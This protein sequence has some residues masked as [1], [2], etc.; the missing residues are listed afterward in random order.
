MIVVLVTMK[1]LRA[2]QIDYC[3]WILSNQIY[4][5][6]NALRICLERALEIAISLYLALRIELKSNHIFFETII[7]L[8]IVTME[9][10]VGYA[11]N[12]MIVSILLSTIITS[13]LIRL[14]TFK[15]T[16]RY[17]LNQVAH[18]EPNRCWSNILIARMF[19]PIVLNK[20]ISIRRDLEID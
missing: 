19:D 7:N 11:A 1:Y 20:L 6:R 17:F 4:L 9:M 5:E 14:V 3:C 18:R 10:E 2:T 15:I 8:S 12:R 16:D 13:I